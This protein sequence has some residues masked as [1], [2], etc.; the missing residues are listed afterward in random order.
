MAN[1][2]RSTMILDVLCRP[3]LKVNLKPTQGFAENKQISLIQKLMHL[4]KE[5]KLTV[6]FPRGKTIHSKFYILKNECRKSCQTSKE[7][8]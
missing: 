1:D 8:D 3:F 4:V 5:Q 2:W 6:F 7:W